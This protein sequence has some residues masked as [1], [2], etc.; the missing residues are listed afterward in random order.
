MPHPRLPVT[1]IYLSISGYKYKDFNKL[2]KIKSVKYSFLS[3]LINHIIPKRIPINHK[4][5]RDLKIYSVSYY[6]LTGRKSS[7]NSSSCF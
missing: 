3:N 5:Y 4:E 2:D 6:S 1:M 7:I